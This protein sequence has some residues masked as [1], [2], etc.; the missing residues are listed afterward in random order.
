M[1]P[2][3]QPER[4][5]VVCDVGELT[6]ADLALVDTLARFQL[7]LGRLDV[8]IVLASAS[9]DLRALIR[10]AG[11]GHVLPVRPASAIE[12]VGQSE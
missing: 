11:L 7:A 5:I 8:G 10:L 1:T 9:D 4:R 6:E 2:R 12:P 3:R